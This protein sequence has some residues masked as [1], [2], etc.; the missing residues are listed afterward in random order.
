MA[1]VR[2]AQQLRRAPIASLD[3]AYPQQKTTLVKSRRPSA[4]STALTLLAALL[5]AV[6]GC[7]SDEASLLAP[8]TCTSTGGPVEN[9]AVDLHCTDDSGHTVTQKLGECTLGAGRPAQVAQVA[10]RAKAAPVRR[11]TRC[12]PRT[13]GSTTIASTT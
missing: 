10:S 3:G 12:S 1:R 4:V 2:R 11:S 6:P 9:G 5:F 13:R 7:G 8:P